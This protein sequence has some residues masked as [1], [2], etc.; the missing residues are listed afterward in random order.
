[1][2]SANLFQQYLQPVRSVQDYAADMDKAEANQLDLQGQRRQNEIAALTADQTRQTMASSAEDRN[3]LQRLAATWG[4]DTSIDQRVASLRNS[5]R[6]ALMQQADALEKQG[7]EKQKTG[8]E[9]SAKNADAIASAIKNSRTWLDGISTPEQYIAWHEANHRDPALGPYL[10]ARGITADQARANIEQALKT[11]GGFERMLMESKLGAE[12]TYANL[13]KQ[14][15]M[16]ETARH[17]KA[18]EASASGQLALSR[19][20]LS[21]EKEQPKGQVVQSDQGMVLVDPRNGKSI[22]I[23]AQDGSPLG[24]KL[25]DLPTA[26]SSAIMS[27]AQNINKVQQ[28]IDLL[29]GKNAGALKGDSNATG[30]KGYLPQPILNRMDPD[31][32]DTRAMVTDIGSLVLHDRS[33]AAV[34]ASETPRLLPFIPLPTDDNAT[35]RKKLVRFKQIYEQEQQAYLDAYSKDQGYKTPKVPTPVPATTG[36]IP[37]VG[38]IEDGHRFKGG[39][40]ADRNNWEKVK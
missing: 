34:T 29:D 14:R 24:P 9:V 28:A 19:D 39:N 26:A 25:K 40:P 31:G 3:A 37:K 2:A 11:P 17:N 16:D 5:G 20:R 7:L 33:G 32:V 18:G 1:M 13:M 23:T 27:N 21:F 4:A 10:E 22:P 15:E 36:S 35:A 30:L 6:P 8:A 12:K 38:T